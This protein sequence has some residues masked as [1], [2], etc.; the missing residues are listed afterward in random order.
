MVPRVN[1]R[2]HD[3][4]GVALILVIGMLA[5]MM[6]LGVTFS[7]FMRS[8][9]TAAANFRVDVQNRE[10]IHVALAEAIRSID[11]SLGTAVYPPWDIL[12][13]SGSG[14]ENL[15]ALSGAVSNWIPWGVLAE[16]NA[17][18]RWCDAG[19]SGGQ[20]SYLVLNC[21]GLLDANYA[22]GAARA[23]GTNTVELQLAALSE[24]G[25]L[26]NASALAANRPYYTLQELGVKTGAFLSKLP[27]SLVVFSNFPTNYTGGVDLGL[28]DL[29]GNAAAL[30]DRKDSI[31]AAL[32]KSGITLAADQEFVFSNLL[33]YVDNSSLPMAPSDLGT[34][35]AKAVPMINEVRV[36]NS[37]IL[38]AGGKCTT[39]VQVDVEWFYPFVK[40]SADSFSIVCDV[41]IKGVGTT[42]PKY[43]PPSIVSQSKSSGYS[44][45]QVGPF[46]DRVQFSI[47]IPPVSYATNDTV[48]L[49]FKIGA[50]VVTGGAVVD[51][52]PYPYASAGYFSVTGK[53]MSLPTTLSGGEKGFECT[54][55]RFNWNTSLTG[56]QWVPYTPLNPNGTIKAPNW[57]TG[58]LFP[59]KY[60]GLYVAGEP[61]HN[62][63]ELSYLLRGS[64]SSDKWNS[65]RVFA[66][67]SVDRVLDCFYVNTTTNRRGFVNVNSR[68]AEVISTVFSGLKLE[69]Y[70]GQSGI[71]AVPAVTPAQ[72]ASLVAELM[73]QTR[74][75]ISRMSDYGTN[76]VF[77]AI[78]NPAGTLSP[79]QAECVL[80]ET[81]GLMH[82]RQN[83]FIV[84]LYARVSKSRGY[85]AVAEIWRDPL[86]NSQGVNP[87]FVRSLRLLND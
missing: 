53:V 57:I 37:V 56:G 72:E 48:Q 24:V 74:S 82:Y 41:E 14:E 40:A 50:K 2:M 25:S 76:M 70:P 29:S 87:R 30:Q 49:A 1:R 78:V 71:V 55:P 45:G 43:V 75:P 3:R 52:V 85:A 60:L 65:V 36:T 58:K 18:P 32:N 61:L 77:Q 73:K 51:S 28:V 39:I 62:V 66:T 64:K 69:A 13:S 81:A 26:A 86:V 84:L 27:H 21:S 34:P 16:T 42:D 10:L 63:G 33:Y 35:L 68:S 80:R 15:F 38:I 9:R 8:E 19:T 12:Q 46:Y 67:N 11:T 31:L 23:S 47:G 54:D 83:F 79:Y 4:S 7:I 5:L 44:A 6:V 59:G 20:Y 22:G 17:A